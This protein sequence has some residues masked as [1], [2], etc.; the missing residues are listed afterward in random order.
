MYSIIELFKVIT[1]YKNLVGFLIIKEL[2]WR[3]VKWVKELRKYY[4]KIKYIKGTK[5]ARAHILNKKMEF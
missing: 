2:N 4:F 5:N 1:D 3:L